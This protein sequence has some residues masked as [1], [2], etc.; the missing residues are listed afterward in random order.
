MKRT[1]LIAGIVCGALG[2]GSGAGALTLQKGPPPVT[3]DVTETILADWHA[4]LD[5]ANLKE[6]APNVVDFRNR[7]TVRLRRENLTFGARLDA[8]MFT[9]P[10]ST[11]YQNDVRP[12]ELYLKARLG[13][14]RLTAGDDYA[15]FG[16]GMALSLR[17]VDDLGFDVSLRGAHAVWA[18]KRLSARV[19]AGFTNVVNV[20]GVDEKLVPD[21]LDLVFATRLEARPTPKIILGAQVVDIERRHSDLL[22]SVSGL[23]PGGVDQSPIGGERF[24]RTTIMGG[25]VELKRLWNRLSLYAEA[26]VLANASERNTKDGF[27][28]VESDGLA[29]YGSATLLFDK[30]SV[31]L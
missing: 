27:E 15:S 23:V 25:N 22:D 29:A 4:K 17:K 28:P 5:D 14:W 6:K 26:N 31:L 10:P 21:P 1:A 8:A 16:R 9:N 18:S 3:M 20:D 30:T 19:H 12:E 13:S 24:L 2:V 7:L 11:Q